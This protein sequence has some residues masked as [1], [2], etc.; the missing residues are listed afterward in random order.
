VINN[1]GE[2][3]S[4]L[5]NFGPRKNWLLV[6]CRGTRSN[7][8]ALGARVVVYVSGRHQSRE[9]QGGSGYISQND[10][11][12]HFGLGDAGGYDRIEVSWPGGAREIFPGGRANR[13]V[14]LREGEGRRLPPSTS[15]PVAS[16]D[17]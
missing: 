9:R 10:P 6:R 4:L 16:P 2:R 17:R 14:E 12:L 13:V 11:R 7:R 5:K 15:V 3:P 1:M 8:D